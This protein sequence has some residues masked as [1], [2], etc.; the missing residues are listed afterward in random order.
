MHK[1]GNELVNL[2]GRE[3]LADTHAGAVARLKRRQLLFYKGFDS[4][5]MTFV[6]QLTVT[7]SFSI[8][9]TSA[10]VLP[11]AGDPAVVVL[12]QGSH[13]D[14]RAGRDVVAGN[15]KAV[16]GGLA[17]Q[18]PQNTGVQAQGLLHAGRQI[19]EVLSGAVL[20]ALAGVLGGAPGVGLFDLLLHAKV[21]L[22]MQDKLG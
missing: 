22:L 20:Q 21:V 8:C 4:A 16:C 3:V 11:L 2:H 1:V 10:S 19:G 15:F 9:L 18:L 12:R 17:R 7:L 13:A 14:G 5:C 6:C